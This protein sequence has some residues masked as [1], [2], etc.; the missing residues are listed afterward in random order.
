[1]PALTNEDT[2]RLPDD[3]EAAKIADIILGLARE[4][5]LTYTGGCRAF[6]SPA[7]WRERG[8]TYG[9]KAL[10]V[11][12][13]DG[14]DLSAFFNYDCGAYLLIDAMTERLRA[15]GLYAEPCTGW[16]TGIYHI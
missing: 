3:A 11:V 1:M 7:E 16:Y 6:Y 2:L 12:V 13:H 15:H 5:D 8:E 9:N 4:R 10:L 14:G